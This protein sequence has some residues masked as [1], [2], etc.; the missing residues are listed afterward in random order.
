MLSY[1][2]SPTQTLHD[3]AAERVVFGVE[4]DR[5][6]LGAGTRVL[7]LHDGKR[8][9]ELA[10][11]GFPDS[12]VWNPAALVG[13]KIADLEPDGWKRYVCV[14]AAA[15]RPQITLSPG[16]SWVGSQRATVI[17]A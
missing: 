4:V 2:N 8:C 10:Q 9:L 15:V 13:G 16:Q 14:E 7:A 11:H 17:E 5:A 6:Y 12:V 1:V 3:E